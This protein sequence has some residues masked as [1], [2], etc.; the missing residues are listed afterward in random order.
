MSEKSSKSPARTKS[1]Q[2]IM[3]APLEKKS[4]VES[5]KIIK[6]DVKFESKE[7]EQAVLSQTSSN[8]SDIEEPSGEEIP[9]IEEKPQMSQEKIGWFPFKPFAETARA[10][11][12]P[13]LS[14]YKAASDSYASFGGILDS[15]ALLGIY[16][17]DYDR[18]AIDGPKLDGKQDAWISK[19]LLSLIYKSEQE[20]PLSFL[21]LGYGI[22]T[23]Y[24]E[25]YATGD[26]IETPETTVEGKKQEYDSVNGDIIF[27][28]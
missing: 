3:E 6:E 12:I 13:A 5:P 16:Y 11:G 25:G 8:L 22:S 9:E 27:D 1:Y 15:T 19:S 14:S 4:N 20:D 28:N 21:I 26:R 17:F 23:L 2:P 10:V 24:W 18:L 7:S